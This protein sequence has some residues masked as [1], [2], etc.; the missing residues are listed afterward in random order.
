MTIRA[1]L[2]LFDFYLLSS[3]L[4]HCIYF[5]FN[6]YAR[7]TQITWPICSELGL[8]P[9]L[10]SIKACT[11]ILNLAAILKKVSPERIV[12]SLEP[13]GHLPW[14]GAGIHIT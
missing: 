9:G 13:L 11:V 5:K 14:E 2:L 4:I 1:Q 12:Y 3:V 8:T 6:C 10:A 7:G